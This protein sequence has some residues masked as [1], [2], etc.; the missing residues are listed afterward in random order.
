MLDLSKQPH[1]VYAAIA[2][3]GHEAIT[4]Y[5]FATYEAALQYCSDAEK[6]DNYYY[7]VVR[8]M[9]LHNSHTEDMLPQSY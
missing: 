3:D 8:S 7:Y 6:R 5:V 2:T 1:N 4:Q 9:Q